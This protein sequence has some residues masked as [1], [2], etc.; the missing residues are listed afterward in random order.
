MV[1]SIRVLLLPAPA[2]PEEGSVLEE[3][4]AC[5]PDAIDA[6]QYSLLERG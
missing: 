2:P 5:L 3:L 6:R 1:T 4:T